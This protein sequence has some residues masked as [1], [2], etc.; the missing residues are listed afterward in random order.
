MNIR[1]TGNS[2][3]KN[4]K[5]PALAILAT[6]TLLLSAI[7]FIGIGAIPQPQ[8]AF[9][10]TSVNQTNTQETANIGTVGENSTVTQNT[11]Q[12]GVNAA[13]DLPP[14]STLAQS[15]QQEALNLLNVT[16]GE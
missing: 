14:G 8:Q 16:G 4:R 13:F 12:A 10:Q 11:D 9:A 15:S 6:A 5:W 7:S 2:G 3:E 1:S